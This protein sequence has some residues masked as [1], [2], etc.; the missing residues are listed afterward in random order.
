MSQ[1]RIAIADEEALTDRA[2]WWC[3]EIPRHWPR[4]DLPPV[5]EC[6]SFAGL[7]ASLSE[8]TGIHAHPGS[9][10]IVLHTEAEHSR[11]ALM[12][13]LD[14][15]IGSHTPA[16]VLTNNP[17]RLR[18]E[19]EAQGVPVEAIY[20][21]AAKIAVIAHALTTRQAAV[22]LLATDLHVARA[23]QGGLTGEIGRLHDELQLAGSLQR[24]LLPTKLPEMDSYE[25]GIFFRPVG[26]VSGDIYDAV[27]IDEH[28]I[29]FMLADA[30]GHG[31]PAALLTLA[32]IH[33]LRSNDN[34][35]TTNHPLASPA[36]TLDRLNLE[37]CE[38]NT[39][40]DRFATAVCGVIDTATGTVT[41]ATGGHPAPLVVDAEGTPTSVSGGE[42]PLLGVFEE[43]EF[44]ETTFTLG[45]GQTLLFYSDGFETAF[46]EPGADPDRA[47]A[48][49]AYIEH[50]AEATT[51]AGEQIGGV[52][53]VIK[54]LA[55]DLDAQAGSLNQRDDLTVVA[56]RRLASVCESAKPGHG[57]AR[58]V[59]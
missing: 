51:H 5:C 26:F 19:L 12:Q 6:V 28:R 40:G 52:Q 13:L 54:H 46:P 36:E 11:S 44:T 56:L 27:R 55:T 39:V 14:R 25:F 31:V 17:A 50:F 43:A 18:P 15:L 42:G 16:I 21:D 2:V 49:E 57:E 32:I 22:E 35:D 9:P 48:N 8:N 4:P 41:L 45:E 23:Q 7:D 37:L 59:A 3:A 29:A 30:V 24:R 38:Q 47:A 20:A 58:A 1:L 34:T 10:V 53:A 33:A